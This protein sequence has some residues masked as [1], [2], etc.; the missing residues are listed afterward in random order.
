MSGFK[1]VLRGPGARVV[2]GFAHNRFPATHDIG[3]L[4]AGL[5]LET[6]QPSCLF[7]AELL[8]NVTLNH[9]QL[10]K[11]NLETPSF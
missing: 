7:I 2:V 10:T 8:L 9:S 3:Y 11:S 6:W 5:N 4:A 1:E